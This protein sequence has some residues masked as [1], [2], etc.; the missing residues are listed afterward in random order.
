MATSLGLAGAGIASATAPTL[1]IKPSATWTFEAFP[2][3]CESVVFNTATHHFHSNLGD[4]GT[5]NGGG[6]T[7][8]MSWTH[9]NSA[10]L[11]FT[12][13]FRKTPSVSY[14]GSTGSGSLAV[15]FRGVTAC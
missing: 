4:K 2:G 13:S 1:H 11:T 5:W 9:G 12:G 15:L 3:L 14:F 6:S 7:I 8:S 10:G